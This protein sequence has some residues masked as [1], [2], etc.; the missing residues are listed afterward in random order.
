MS[1]CE[2]QQF[3]DFVLIDNGVLYPGPHR[4]VI[5][6]GMRTIGAFSNSFQC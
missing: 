2:F 3:I 1:A 6:N 4:Q 5:A